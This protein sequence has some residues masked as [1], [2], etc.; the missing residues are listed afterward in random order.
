MQ[1]MNRD[2]GTPLSGAD[3]ILQSIRDIL[4]TP[5]G[6]RV[7]LPEYGSDLF[8]LVDHPVD[9]TTSIK[10]VMA[11]A[12]ALARWEPRIRVEQVQAVG[13]SS[14]KITLNL[15][16]TDVETRRRLNFDNLELRF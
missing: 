5:L 14:G 16:A 1:G 2:T 7:M 13:L 4:E 3:H 10:V 11:T 9:G 15:V 6:T 8:R 12:G